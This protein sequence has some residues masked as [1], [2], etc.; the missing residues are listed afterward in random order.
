MYQK[1]SSHPIFYSRSSFQYHINTTGVKPLTLYQQ[2]L[3]CM[4]SIHVKGK[5]RELSLSSEKCSVRDDKIPGSSGYSDSII[6]LCV[7]M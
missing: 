5:K 3:Y 7:L 4:A 1:S 6:S 2:V